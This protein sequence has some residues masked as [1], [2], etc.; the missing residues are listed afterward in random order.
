M[1]KEKTKKETEE[2]ETSEPAEPAEKK[3]AAE[4]RAKQKPE[5][6][7]PKRT[8]QE[9]IALQNLLFG[10]SE[11]KLMVSDEFLNNMAAKYISK[12][13]KTINANYES[14]HSTKIPEMFFKYCDEI[15]SC[16]EELIVLEPYYSFKNPVP[17]VYKRSFLNHKP[18]ALTAM[19]NRIWRNALQKYPLGKPENEISERAME[20][21]DEAINEML[22]FQDRMTE[23]DLS[24]IDS[25]YKQVHGEEELKEETAEGETPQESSENEENAAE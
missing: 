2:K 18:A 9:K 4:K 22:K 10:T 8:K 11:K 5:D 24:L 12:R 14:I 17:T 19:L 13:M 20:C 6:T 16:L 7:A 25:F 23:D 1:A 21:Y 3:P 15:E